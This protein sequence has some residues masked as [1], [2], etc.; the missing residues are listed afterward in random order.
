M[1][2]ISWKWVAIVVVVALM[3]GFGKASVSVGGT[4][5]TTGEPVTVE[6]PPVDSEPGPVDNALNDLGQTIP[7]IL[8]AAAIGG[9]LAALANLGKMFPALAAWLDGKTPLVVYGL[10]V[11]VLILVT[12]AGWFGFGDRMKDILEQGAAVLPAA[13]SLLALLFSFASSIGGAAGIHKL[14]KSLNKTVFSL[15]ARKLAGGVGGG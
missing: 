5:A 15:S 6:V 9:I 2:N 11:L 13:V 4:N 10:N 12:V 8:S 1:Q 3:F 14:M 7:Q